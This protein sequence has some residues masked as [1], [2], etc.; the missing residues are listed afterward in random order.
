MVAVDSAVVARPRH[1]LKLHAARAAKIGRELFERIGRARRRG[2]DERGNH[3]RNG[4][5]NA[6]PSVAPQPEFLYVQLWPDGE[7][8]GDIKGEF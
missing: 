7:H 3:V 2:A 8:H 5:A 1:P 6:S 4:P